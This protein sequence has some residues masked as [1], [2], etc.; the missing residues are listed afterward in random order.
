MKKLVTPGAKGSR[1]ALLF[2]SFCTFLVGQPVIRTVCSSQCDYLPSQLQTAIDA[3]AAAN[4]TASTPWIIRVGSGETFDS[5][6]GLKLRSR[7]GN[8]WIIIESSRLSEL[9]NRVS[10]SDAPNMPRLRETGDDKGAINTEAGASYYWLRG[11]EI[12][13]PDG[14]TGRLNLLSIGRFDCFGSGC[15]SKRS[16]MP[17]HIIVERSY[18]HGNPLQDGPRRCILANGNHLWI[19]GNHIDE[20]KEEDADAQ[21]IS[22]INSF[23]PMS[24]E[25]NVLRATGEVIM[26]GG[27]APYVDGAVPSN[28]VIR[29]NKLS[30][31]WHWK[32]GR[33]TGTPSGT[34]SSDAESGEY[35]FNTETS[36]GYRCVGGSWRSLGVGTEENYFVVKNIFEIKS[37]SKT[38]LEGNIL[39]RSWNAAQR[40][41]AILFNAVDND[42]GSGGAT[43]PSATITYNVVRHNIVR[44]AL[45]PIMMTGN[46]TPG[47]VRIK[48]IGPF[49]IQAGVNDRLRLTSSKG[50]ASNPQTCDITLPADPSMTVEELI[51]NFNTASSSNGC[52]GAGWLG[53]IYD[54]YGSIRIRGY[55]DVTVEPVP[56]SAYLTI[57]LAL[58]PG[59]TA[60]ELQ[61][62]EAYHQP[63]TGNSIINNVFYQVGGTRHL[64]F[65]DSI[66]VIFSGLLGANDQVVAHNTMVADMDWPTTPNAYVARLTQAS[67]ERFTFVNNIWPHNNGWRSEPIAGATDAGTVYGGTAALERDIAYPYFF[68][69]VY[70]NNC[71]W[72]TAEWEGEYNTIFRAN[73]M[74]TATQ[75]GLTQ[76]CD[77]TSLNGYDQNNAIGFHNFRSHN[78]RLL[79]TSPYK[80]SGVDGRDPGADVDLVEWATAKA[81]TGAINSFYRMEIKNVAATSNGGTVRYVAPDT[82]ACTIAI[83][84]SAKYSPAVFSRTDDGGAMN[85]TMAITGLSPNMRYLIRAVCG[86]DSYRLESEFR[87]RP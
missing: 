59:E 85:R 30:K 19:R 37:G 58:Q 6:A 81:D 47:F 40:G 51:T 10:P 16:E 2:F 18:I 41:H 56:N 42:N 76:P 3:A 67:T 46:Q 14:V 15:D 68:K 45:E 9:P 75:G 82:A 71:N 62:T 80:G 64:K 8:G 61:W 52:G 72:S 53:I 84:T 73:N 78:Y 70:V 43:N 48:G 13:I 55:G 83:G 65:G 77:A 23:G 28:V 60:R 57:N 26:L 35:F 69:N 66:G 34:C 21:A 25:N 79:A 1:L 11:L 24:I 29:G 87:T 44:D 31:K 22:I 50:Y 4:P 5:L 32:H 36:V 74:L 17:H 20:C 12:T 54:K 63:M 38:L 49:N 27:A 7:S 39:E 86:A 33:G